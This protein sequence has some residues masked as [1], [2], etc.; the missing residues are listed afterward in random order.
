M[1]STFACICS[2]TSITFK[3]QETRNMMYHTYKS[4]PFTIS[5]LNNNKKKYERTVDI[6]LN[7]QQ[8]FTLYLNITSYFW[9]NNQLVN[10][11]QKQISIYLS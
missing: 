6:Q 4:F 7:K 9:S 8:I 5:L 11:L 1:L 2:I 3:L 10:S